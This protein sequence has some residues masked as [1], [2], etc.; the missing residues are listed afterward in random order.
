MLNGHFTAITE[1]IF[2]L[3][4]T[5]NKFI[6]DEIMCVFGA[7]FT[8]EDDPLNAVKAGLLIQRGVTD[9]NELR[10]REGRPVFMV[11]VGI[12]TGEVSAGYIGSPMRME[13]TVIG[14]RVNVASRPAARRS[15]GRWS[16]ARTRGKR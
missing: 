10:E 3:K 11:G 7:P 13:Y 8:R 16:S 9:L 1:I 6:G 15:R 5:I 14:D 2:E 4:G 12:E